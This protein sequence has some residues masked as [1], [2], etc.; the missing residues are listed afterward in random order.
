MTDTIC[1]HTRPDGKDMIWWLVIDGKTTGE[2]S[3]S[4]ICDLLYQMVAYYRH[5]GDE[6]FR[7]ETLSGPVKMN[8]SR[9]YMF[10]MEAISVMSHI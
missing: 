6:D 2:M 4:Q 7:L 1:I 5:G 9:V 3:R 8:R 10:G